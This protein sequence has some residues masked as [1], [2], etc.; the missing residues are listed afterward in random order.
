[1][2]LTIVLHEEVVKFLESTGIVFNYS[3]G[4]HAF[5]VNN[6]IYRST[7][8]NGLYTIQFLEQILQEEEEDEY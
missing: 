7:E 2:M 1:M 8:E 3:D 4:T 6:T 5:Q